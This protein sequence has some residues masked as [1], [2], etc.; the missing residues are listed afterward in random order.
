MFREDSGLYCK[1]FALIESRLLFRVFVEVDAGTTS[2]TARVFS[3]VSRSEDL[4]SMLQRFEFDS[5]NFEFFFVIR[6]GL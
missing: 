3:L 5:S 4:T 6:V 1:K 2:E